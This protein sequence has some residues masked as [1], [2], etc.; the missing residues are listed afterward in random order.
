MISRTGAE[1]DANETLCQFQ[2]FLNQMFLPAD[3]LWTLAM[4]FNVYLALFRRY[5]ASQLRQQEWK[6]FIICYGIPFIPAITFVFARSEARGRIFGPAILWCWITAEW[7]FLRIAFF[8]GPVWAILL[9]AMSIYAVIGRVIYKNHRQFRNI[10]RSNL[11]SNT[12]SAAGPKRAHPYFN[13][14]FK[15]AIPSV[16]RAAWA[17]MKIALLFYAAMLITWVTSPL[18]PPSLPHAKL[19]PSGRSDY[20]PHLHL[21][22]LPGCLLSPKLYGGS[23][24]SLAGLLER[25]HLREHVHP[26]MPRPLGHAVL[27]QS[28]RGD[29]QRGR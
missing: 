10:P 16:D 12:D 1:A 29:A 6:Y 8:Y 15:P 19:S 17:Y 7:N 20:K 2:A 14:H 21:R 5:S 26:G 27:G 9:T 22:Q 4:A 13:T 25:H 28:S 11:S 3:S 24:S 18:T 23:R